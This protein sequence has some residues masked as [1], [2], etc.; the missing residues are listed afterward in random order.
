MVWT[1]NDSLARGQP[2]E[3][4][5]P[6]NRPPEEPPEELPRGIL[7]GCKRASPRTPRGVPEGSPD[8]TFVHVLAANGTFKFFLHTF[9]YYL[10]K[11]QK[12]YV[13]LVNAPNW[14][15]ETSAEKF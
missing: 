14:G 4:T 12:S 10:A 6:P 15:T 9:K 5:Q 7:E 11:T 13:R 3:L 2:E 8:K 1:E